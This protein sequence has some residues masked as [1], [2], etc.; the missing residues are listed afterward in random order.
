MTGAIRTASGHGERAG[1]TRR[2]RLAVLASA[3]L[4]C[5]CLPAGALA[6]GNRVM[7]KVSRRSVKVHATFTLMASGEAAQRDVL[8]QFLDYRPC[9]AGEKAEAARHDVSDH[10]PVSGVF[11]VGPVTASSGKAG[12]DHACAYLVHHG[13]TVARSV[14]TF[15]V[16]R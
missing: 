16:V 5:A 9:A 4:L 13:R 3:G 10:Q 6:L 7:E 2:A 8:W 1:G 15:S 12:G 14:A 11:R